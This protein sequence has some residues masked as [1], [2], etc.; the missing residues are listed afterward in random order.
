MR[1]ELHQ[2]IER[3]KGVLESHGRQFTP[4][5]GVSIAELETLQQKIGYRLDPDLCDFYAFSNGGPDYNEWFA[6]GDKQLESAD[7][8]TIEA[9]LK[10]WEM[11]SQYDEYN[12]ERAK[13][14]QAGGGVERDSRIAPDLWFPPQWWH[15]GESSSSHQI[16]FDAIPS[17]LGKYGQIVVYYHDPDALTYGG[18]SF[19]DFFRKST[20]LLETRWNEIYADLEESEDLDK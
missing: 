3:L 1:P 2:Q 15:F 17:P 9:S 4:N 13:E 16:I 19:L 7:L 5:K 12:R 6:I 10:R 14:I 11:L 8:M 18:D 20:T